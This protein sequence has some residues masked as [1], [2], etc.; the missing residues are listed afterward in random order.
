[1]RNYI[2]RYL[3][4][5]PILSSLD[6]I[7]LH[8]DGFPKDYH[9]MKPYLST[10]GG[11]RAVLTLLML[12]RAFQLPAE[13]NLST[14]TGI[15]DEAQNIISDAELAACYRKLRVRSGIVRDWTQPHFSTK[16]GPQGQALLSSL[17]ELTLLP[18]KLLENISLIGGQSL[19]K[20]IDENLEGLDV[21]E[22]IKP[23]EWSN[24]QGNLMF[25]IAEW[26]KW[27][28]PTKSKNLRKLS[29]FGDK[30]G[31]TRVIAI[32]DYWS[33][34]SL[35]PLH[36]CVNKVLKSL[37]MDCT[38]N[39]NSFTEKNL[40][41]IKGHMFHSIDLTAA[42]DRMPISLQKRVVAHL[43]N[44]E[45]KANAWTEIMV[46]QDFIV[47]LP[48]KEVVTVKYAKGQPMGAYS[49][50]PVMALTHHI[51][52]QLAAMRAGVVNRHKLFTDYC[53]LGDD[54]RI[55]HDLVSDAYKSLI[56]QLGMPFSE[57]KTHD[58]YH[59][60]EFAKR[61]FYKGEEITGFSVSG[62][63]SVW[64]SYPLLLNFLDNQASHGWKLPLERHPD[65]ILQLHK[66]IKGD[67]FIYN[68]TASMISLYMLFYYVRNIKNISLYTVPLTEELFQNIVI[69][70]SDRFGINLLAQAR[71][72]IEPR[73][74][75]EQIYLEAKRNIVEKD[76]L[77]FQKE[78][79]K[80]NARL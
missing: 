38:F 61:W 58:S 7:A 13:P 80:V 3:L 9:Y 63:L 79:F 72:S 40:L 78:A 69:T 57:N 22:M 16:K 66:K 54:L 47:K 59:G 1:M 14:I 19:R 42:T 23:K 2:M 12:T 73:Q 5:N 31:K 39:Q 75:L 46:G 45:Q 64:K 49:S 71:L 33:Q 27:L 76:L 28:F 18:P 25:S 48:S 70:L 21:L 20:L 44:S 62:L 8:K 11:V 60:F 51:I 30:E 32:F 52:V 65:L 67:N 4:G 41:P 37:P 74:I 36:T 10:T 29:Y 50:W 6:G 34:T 68:K 35:R 77:T 43:F 56:L 17:S 26:W 55:D 53:L 24:Q 15:A